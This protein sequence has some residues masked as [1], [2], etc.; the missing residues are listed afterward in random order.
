MSKKKL[1]DKKGFTLAEVL[2]AVLILSLLGT[3][4]A[5]GMPSALGAYRKITDIANAQALLS[6]TTN[7][8]RNRLDLADKISVDDTAKTL[9]FRSVEGGECVISSEANGVNIQ[10]YVDYKIGAEGSETTTEHK[11]LLVSEEASAKNLQISFDSV[12][13]SELNGTIT[14]SGIKV[15]KKD[16]APTDSDLTSLD[17]FVIKTL[18]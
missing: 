1:S 17:E 4:I 16:A 9:S 10:E 7:A 14:F 13:Y 18:D 3:I 15:R 2:M 11:R 12:A 5:A 8:L 6:T